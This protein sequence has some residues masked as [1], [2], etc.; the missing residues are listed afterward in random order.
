MWWWVVGISVL[1]IF[2]LVLFS[3]IK[4]RVK[5]FREGENDEVDAAITALFGLVQ[6]RYN[7]PTIELRPW[8]QGIRMDV[9]KKKSS[10]MLP[11]LDFSREEMQRFFARVRTLIVHMKNYKAWLEGTLQHIHV[12]EFRWGTR[13]GL[14]DAPETGIASG[15][16]WSMK[17]MVVGM[18]SRWVTLDERPIMSVTPMFQNP[19]FRTDVYVRTRVRVHRLIAIGGML[20]F[21]VIRK[22]GGWKV[23]FRVLRDALM[24]KRTV[25]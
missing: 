6:L 8:L 21:R 5:Y 7:V 13:F 23:W 2:V 10:D 19:K 24:H 14:D 3:N 4:V 25:A 16:L 17:S 9:S 22:K 12:V 1:A 20:M 18:M 15:V 11:T